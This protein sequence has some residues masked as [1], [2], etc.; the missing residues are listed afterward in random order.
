MKKATTFNA[1]VETIDTARTYRGAWRK[2]QRCLIPVYAIYEWQRAG[3]GKVPWAISR[4]DET[5][6]ALA[7]LY[8]HSADG[9]LTCTVITLEPNDLFRPLH[10]RMAMVMP[11]DDYDAWLNPDVSP[12]QARE[13][14]TEWDSS[15]YQAYR[16]SPVV[17]NAR[18]DGPE[19]LEP[20]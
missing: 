8:E 18:N 6:F 14:I 2:G 3:K 10:H 12:E 1:R 20:V 5:P 4:M 9:A 16:V 17:N 15:E 19:C 11:V 7:G 13:L